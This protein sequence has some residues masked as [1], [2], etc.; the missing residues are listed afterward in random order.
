[1]T[2]TLPD[3]AASTGCTFTTLVADARAT[4]RARRVVYESCVRGKV[5][6]ELVDD[7]MGIA[8]GLVHDMVAHEGGTVRL[9]VQA[10]PGEV[11]VTVKDTAG[12]ESSASVHE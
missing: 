5:A 2:A 4:R 10:R 11:T 1:M 3:R 9:E 7:A 8:A 6:G 12:H